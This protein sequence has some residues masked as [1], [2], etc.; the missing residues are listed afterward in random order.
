MVTSP[1]TTPTSARSSSEIAA[2]ALTGRARALAVRA[3]SPLV[4]LVTEPAL[5]LLVFLGVSLGIWSSMEQLLRTRLPRACAWI[6]AM[7]ACSC[8][9]SSAREMTS[10]CSVAG[11]LAELCSDVDYTRVRV[12]LGDLIW[13]VPRSCHRVA[14]VK[15]RIILRHRMTCLRAS[16]DRVEAHAGSPRLSTGCG[17]LAAGATTRRCASPREIEHTRATSDPLRCAQRRSG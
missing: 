14:W 6:L 12:L 16:S 1:R 11:I 8:S 7:E 15:T 4:S 2:A 3:L 9:E 17:K 5:V 13:V 10:S